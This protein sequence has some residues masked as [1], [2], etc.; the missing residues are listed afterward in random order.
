ME[1][2]YVIPDFIMQWKSSN[3][4]S[5]FYQKVGLLFIYHGIKGTSMIFFI[6]LLI[7]AKFMEQLIYFGI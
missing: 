2:N 4:R 7:G 1:T 6:T 5:I 3:S